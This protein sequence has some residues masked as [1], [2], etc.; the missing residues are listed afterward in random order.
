[1]NLKPN[2]VTL[3]GALSACSQLGAGQEGEKVYNY[4]ICEKLNYNVQVC[5]AVIDMYANVGLWIK[6]FG[7]LVI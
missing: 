3:L 1:M 4:I 6:L 7:F 2:E 5:S